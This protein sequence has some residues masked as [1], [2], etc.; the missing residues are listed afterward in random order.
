MPWRR[1]DGVG[2]PGNA[3]HLPLAQF[4]RGVARRGR[5]DVHRWHNECALFRTPVVSTAA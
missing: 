2:F 3:S 4:L 1:L 5:K